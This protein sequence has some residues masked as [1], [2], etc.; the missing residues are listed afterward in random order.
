VGVTTSVAASPGLEACLQAIHVGSA[1]R[2][3]HG[4][5]ETDRRSLIALIASSVADLHGHDVGDGDGMAHSHGHDHHATTPRPPR[6]L[7]QSLVTAEWPAAGDLQAFSHRAHAA[8]RR[9]HDLSPTTG[10]LAAGSAKGPRPPLRR[11]GRR[12]DP[13]AVDQWIMEALYQTMVVSI[14]VA[15]LIFH[16]RQDVTELVRPLVG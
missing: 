11:T 8:W 5:D 16:Y 2:R 7:H 12:S 15:Y 13:H 14:L 6:T 9:Q 1:D 3:A 10:I 4:E